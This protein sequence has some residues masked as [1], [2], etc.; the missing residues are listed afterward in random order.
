[1]SD[2]YHPMMN[3]TWN[4]CRERV[5]W[6]GPLRH[7]SE[8]FVCDDCATWRLAVEDCAPARC[9]QSKQENAQHSFRFDRGDPYIVCDA[10]GQVRSV[11]G[12]GRRF[13]GVG[14]R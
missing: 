13:T 3:L 12:C 6:T 14:K 4:V 1:M 9:A 10:C 2:G 8:P 7:G 5:T 11:S